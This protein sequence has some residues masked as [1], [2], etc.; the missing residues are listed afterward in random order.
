[1]RPRAPAVIPPY[2]HLF[3]IQVDGYSSSAAEFEGVFRTLDSILTKGP[4]AH[5]QHR[6]SHG[7]PAGSVFIGERKPT[8]IRPVAAFLG[9][10]IGMDQFGNG[11]A[12]LPHCG[13]GLSIPV[14]FLRTTAVPGDF[15]ILTRDCH[16]H[17]EA[18]E[19]GQALHAYFKF[20]RNDHIP[21]PIHSICDGL[22][23]HPGRQHIGSSNN[24]NGIPS[25]LGFDLLYE[26]LRA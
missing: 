17:P 13:P 21:V 9:P 22:T 14:R 4:G 12:I 26:P 2:P 20:V 25:F 23:R 16:L 6:I 11:P 5:T 15:F 10:D 7:Q 3:K 19:V 1:M 18:R 24:G 8:N